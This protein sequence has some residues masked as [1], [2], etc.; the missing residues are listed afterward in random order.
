MPAFEYPSKDAFA[1]MLQTLPHNEIID[2]YIFVKETPFAFKD[3]KK[4]YEFLVN[5]IAKSLQLN[6]D[7]VT[8]VGSGRIGFSL[9]PR[10]FGTPF[11]PRSDLDIAIVDSA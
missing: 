9:S 10:Q 4:G 5:H 11:S 8:L 7:C 6:S 1:E 3:R 2:K